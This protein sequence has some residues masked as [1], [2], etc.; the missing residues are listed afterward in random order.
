MRGAPAESESQREW[1]GIPALGGVGKPTGGEGGEMAGVVRVVPS[2]RR[3][4]LGSSLVVPILL[5]R[6]LPQGSGPV[7][8]VDERGTT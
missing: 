7:V 4:G 3:V 6:W 1:N 8:L 2:C 5:S